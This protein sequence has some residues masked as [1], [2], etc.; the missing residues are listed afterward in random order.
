[1][2]INNFFSKISIILLVSILVLGVNSTLFADQKKVDQTPEE[3]KIGAE[4][5]SAV[6]QRRCFR[7]RPRKTKK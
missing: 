3:S 1:M 4:M 5:N 2:R 6:T 7:R